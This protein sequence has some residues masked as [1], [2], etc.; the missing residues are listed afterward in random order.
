MRTV[1]FLLGLTLAA[2]ALPAAR[3]PVRQ[4]TTADGLAR[5]SVH[6]IIRDR[7]GFLWFATG[8]GI[9]RFNGYTFSNYGVT[10]GLPDRDVRAI[11]QAQDG[12]FLVATGGGAARFKPAEP[13]PSNRFSVYP[14]PAGT[15]TRSVNAIIDRGSTI[16]IGTDAGLYAARPGVELVPLLVGAAQP[17]ITN[18]LRDPAQNLWIGTSAGLFRIDPAGRI[19][20]PFP[21]PFVTTLLLDGD[22]LWIGTNAGLAKALLH[23]SGSF[24]LTGD[25]PA[26]L[27][28]LEIRSLLRAHDGSLWIGTRS[29]VAH[30]EANS[31]TIQWF[32]E[33]EGFLKGDMQTLAEDGSGDLWAGYDGA[34]AIR[35]SSNGFLTFDDR[36]GL[37][38]AQITSLTV[39]R[40]GAPLVTT[41]ARPG[42]AVYRLVQDHF[43]RHDLGNG[44]SNNASLF[45]DVWLPW[46]QVIA[47]DS[48]G[49]W[50]T[51]SAHGL[52]RFLPPAYRQNSTYG[53]AQ[54]LPAQNV[55]HVFEDSRGNIWFSTLPL[56][57]YP[58]PGQ[59]SGLGVWERTTGSIRTFTEADGLPPL[60]SV[61]I[62]YIAE[63]HGGHIWIGLYRTGVA[64]LRDGRFQVFTPSDGIPTG[65]IRYIYEDRQHRLWLG[66]GRGGLG[67]I[68][69]PLAVKPV[70]TR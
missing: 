43:Q 32:G 37:P 47:E 54:G 29:R 27:Q 56:V 51:G 12:G 35:V 36:D 44:L 3:L 34:G 14:L 61:V 24:E 13:A 42:L 6:R 70:V 11:V 7:E 64:R 22:S 65:G 15:K 28:N 2:C 30:R 26:A 68:D 67:R 59:H 45:P 4:Y 33:P 17:S 25:S 69:D 50:W 20:R 52:L 62:L 10:D 48:R 21:A 57:A 8:E 41:L 5:D 39:T 55:A 19:H 40:D 23:S 16:W 9:S 58:P 60:N 38:L 46:H 31:P 18:L 63:D 53:T 49:A 66:S 1:L